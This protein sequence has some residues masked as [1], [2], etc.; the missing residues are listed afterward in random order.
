MDDPKL[1]HC[2]ATLVSSEPHEI[3][4]FLVELARDHPSASHEELQA[5]LT[6][7]RRCS[8]PSEDREEL[9]AEVSHVLKDEA[10]V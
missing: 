2:D 4:R 8:Q 3:S 5:A 1:R 7:A 6:K 10:A 9:K